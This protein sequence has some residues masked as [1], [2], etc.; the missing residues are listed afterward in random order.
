MSIKTL[1]I[2]LVINSIG[3]ALRNELVQPTIVSGHTIPR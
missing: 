2:D 1:G 3:M